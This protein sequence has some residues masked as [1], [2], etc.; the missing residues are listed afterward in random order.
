MDFHRHWHLIPP[1][2]S[3]NQRENIVNFGDNEI[4]PDCMSWSRDG[5]VETFGRS[6]HMN[7]RVIE[8]RDPVKRRSKRM[9][10]A[11]NP[12]P[13]NSVENGLINSTQRQPSRHEQAASIIIE[14]VDLAPPALSMSSSNPSSSATGA[15][16]ICSGCREPG[17]IYRTCGR[18][19]VTVVED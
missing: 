8:I 2:P 1:S 15:Q 9:R 16:H 14:D 11:A 18:R 3:E 10:L 12:T 6:H 13:T 17:H 19:R 4:A 5:T 7:P